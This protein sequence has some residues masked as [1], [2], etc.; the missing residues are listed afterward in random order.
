MTSNEI[1]REITKL[2][3][4]SARFEIRIADADRALDVLSHKYRPG[5]VR[6]ETE[7]RPHIGAKFSAENS[8]S[9]LRAGI[10]AKTAEL[11]E[12]I[13]QEQAPTLED[14]HAALTKRRAALEADFK[15]L[16]SLTTETV[17]VLWRIG[18]PCNHWPT[19]RATIAGAIMRAARH[20]FGG[21]PEQ[22]VRFCALCTTPN[23]Q[24]SVAEAEENALDPETVLFFR[25]PEDLP[26]GERTHHAE[27]RFIEEQIV[28]LTHPDMLQA[29]AAEAIR[30]AAQGPDEDEDATAETTVNETTEAAKEGSNTNG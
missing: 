10:E 22:M 28:Q 2:Q 8:L 15:R 27:L 19:T 24:R 7:R 23:G 30:R 14:L 1:A 9:A 16:H 20:A 3:S 26:E 12:A 18:P 25:H 17:A 5:D 29:L 4:E 13:S 6:G 11:V 21:L